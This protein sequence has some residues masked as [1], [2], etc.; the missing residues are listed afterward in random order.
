M[1]KRE[2]SHGRKKPRAERKGDKTNWGKDIGSE[3]NLGV[4]IR[5]KRSAMADGAW[6]LVTGHG[7]MTEKGL[8]LKS[9]VLKAHM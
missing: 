8:G 5:T 2:R 3:K 1:E 9:K 4:G 6:R 7:L